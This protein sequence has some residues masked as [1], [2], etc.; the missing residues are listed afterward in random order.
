[1]HQALEGTTAL[2]ACMLSREEEDNLML[3]KK[4]PPGQICVCIKSTRYE[5]QHFGYGGC[6]NQLLRSSQ[7]G[8]EKRVCFSMGREM[9]RTGAIMGILTTVVDAENANAS[10]AWWPHTIRWPS[11]WEVLRYSQHAEHLRQSGEG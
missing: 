2:P 4:H 7:T 11:L 6:I 3:G 5:K 8:R 10:Y 9:M 1:M